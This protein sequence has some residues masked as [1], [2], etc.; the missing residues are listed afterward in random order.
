MT[1]AMLRRLDD[2]P[3]YDEAVA[4]A[5]A[6]DPDAKRVFDDA[7]YAL[8]VL[9]G[10]AANFIDP[11]K[12]LLTGDGLPLHEVSGQRVTEGV[13]AAYEA[14]PALIDLDVQPFDFDEWARSGAALAI[15]AALTGPPRP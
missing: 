9:I 4:R 8:G 14:D 15:R 12:V 6:G 13:E 2:R 3:T 5:R 7:G 10:T 11:Q 1:H